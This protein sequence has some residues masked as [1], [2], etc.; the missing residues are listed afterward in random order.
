MQLGSDQAWGHGFGLF[1]STD[2]SSAESASS[3][4][5]V[6]IDTNVVV[7]SEWELS[8]GICSEGKEIF[9]LATEIRIS[10][11]EFEATQEQMVSEQY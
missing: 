4:E 8:E 11:S 3:S 6:V 10:Q 2:G 5:E 9:G 1:S 7:D